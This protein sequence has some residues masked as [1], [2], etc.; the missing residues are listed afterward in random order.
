MPL[1]PPI[2][3]PSSF[4]VS[5]GTAP[6]L[7]SILSTASLST[8]RASP[9]PSTAL[10]CSLSAISTPP[11]ASASRPTWAGTATTI[12]VST[13]ALTSLPLGSASPNR[14]ATTT[15][16]LA[17]TTS[18]MLPTLMLRM[19]MPQSPLPTSST[20]SATAPTRLF[21]SSPTAQ[22]HALGV[23]SSTRTTLPRLSIWP[24]TS[25]PPTP[26]WHTPSPTGRPSTWA[27]SIRK[28][29]S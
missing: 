21:S 8:I 15:T 4:G 27:S 1:P 22:Q 24:R 3:P 19:P 10:S 16:S 13:E 28:A 29:L 7:S 23:T 6:S 26:A 2:R 18:S 9:T 25:M 17:S 14:P 12:T 11:Q 5:T 20:G